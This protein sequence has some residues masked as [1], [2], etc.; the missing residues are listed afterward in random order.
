MIGIWYREEEKSRDH[1]YV[2]T[3]IVYIYCLP[4]MYLALYQ[5]QIKHLTA[6]IVHAPHRSSNLMAKKTIN[7]EMNL[8]F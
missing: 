2:Y 1:L 7:N 4:I 3:F 5:E 6:D 8:K